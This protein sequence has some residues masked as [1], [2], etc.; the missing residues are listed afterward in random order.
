MSAAGAELFQPCQKQ[1]AV[2]RNSECRLPGDRFGGPDLSVTNAN[3]VFLLAMIY[4]DLPPVKI[5]LQH[6]L[7]LAFEIR[8]Q[9]ISL[10]MM[11]PPGVHRSPVRLWGNHQEAKESASRSSLP[12]D[13][14][15]LFVPDVAPCASKMNPALLPGDRLVLSDR[16]G[17]KPLF[18]VY[19]PSSIGDREA[20][21]C[22]L[23]ATTN[24]F[25][26]RERLQMDT[27]P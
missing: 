1:K 15:D 12:Q 17:R 25:Y 24:D 18:A 10:V 11:V 8:T 22:I 21:P 23:S 4:L 7:R 13:V 27:D 20:Q 9:K 5:A 2:A 3:S 14:A 26:A 16:F 19:A 6:S